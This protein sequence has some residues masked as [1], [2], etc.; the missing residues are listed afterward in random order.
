M[1]KILSF[2]AMFAVILMGAGLFF[3]QVVSA[4]EGEL[5]TF[6]SQTYV[7]EVGDAVNDGSGSAVATAFEHATWYPS[8]SLGSGATWIWHEALV[9]D[10]LEDHM[11]V[12]NKTVNVDGNF[13]SANIEIA[14]DNGYRIEV[15]GET[16]VD[17]L[18]EE[19]N[20]E[21]LSSHN[22]T[23]NSGEN[24]I[25]FTVNNF[26]LEGST[27]ETNPAG[28]L[29]KLVVNS[30]TCPEIE[31]SCPL[32]DS[33]GDDDEETII[34]N[35]DESRS[36]QEMIEVY[37]LNADSDQKQYQL[38]NVPENQD[39]E[40]DAKFIDEGADYS[41]VFGYYT[42]S[43]MTNFVPIFKTAAITGYEGVPLASEGPF[44][45]NTGAAVT[46]GFAIKAFNDETPAG[47]FT[48]ENAIGTGGA[49]QAIVYNPSSNEYV[50]AFEDLV[51]GDSDYNDMVVE[52][53]LDCSE[54]SNENQAPTAV[55]DA[56]SVNENVAL[57]VPVV[58]GVLS[59]DTDPETDT[60]TAVLVNNVSNGS[61]TLSADGSFTYTPNTN[62]SG[63]DSFTY[64][65]NDG[66]SDSNTVTVSITVNHIVGT[67]AECSDGIDNSDPEDTL[68]DELDPGCHSDGNV[69]NTE[70]YV[71]NDID[72]TDES[73]GGDNPQCSDGVDNIDPEDTLADTLDPGCHSDGNP[74]NTGSYIPSDN[75]ETDESGGT[76]G[77]GGG[78]RS[79]RECSDRRDNDND[80]LV[81][82]ADPGCHSDG[83]AD[84][85]D[86]YMPRDNDER[87]GEVLGAET[88]CGIYVDKYLRVGYKND[89]D[90]VK[91][92]QQF[93]N[94]YMKSGLELD[95]IYGPKTAAAVSV[96]QL[97]HKEKILAPW[98]I[99]APT[100][101]FYL[102]TQTEVNNIM[103]PTLELPIPENLINFSINPATPAP[104]SSGLAIVPPPL[105]N[106]LY[107]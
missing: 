23:L 81:D 11:D 44:T 74:S 88:S 13:V 107:N 82:S 14:A 2:V 92:V 71:P 69:N 55:A 28:L 6:D 95:G 78:S 100:G 42:D 3:P 10:P 26:A 41:A 19:H 45:V 101:I 77:G 72:E 9:S 8:A 59:N 40:I 63:F 73:G 7:S 102:T 33:L 65:A 32:P 68:A 52:V 21:A 67:D 62:Y 57:I 4:T 34:V 56:Y 38:W 25:A 106:L 17:K 97:A 64:K 37:G 60:L 35:P 84:N 90:S 98:E 104:I 47:Y 58:S 18:N 83:N 16:I 39:I 46:I 103:C 54:I 99:N 27:S 96:F 80:N 36:L 87:N 53:V 30:E 61:L 66:T 89:V 5:C 12:F 93:L 76:G 29:Y 75:D 20:Y 85:E 51:N 86:S 15:N 24:M 79:R 91:E 50:I 43:S 22:L 70:S 105:K 31:N 1:K 94:D 48:T 49:D